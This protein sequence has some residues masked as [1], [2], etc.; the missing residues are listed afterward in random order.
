LK[1][2]NKN[3]SIMKSSMI[4]FMILFQRSKIEAIAHPSQASQQ[5]IQLELGLALYSLFVCLGGLA[6][7]NGAKCRVQQ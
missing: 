1:P 5:K 7:L 4:L 2:E 3:E 6:V